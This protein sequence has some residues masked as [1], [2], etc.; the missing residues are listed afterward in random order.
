M[1]I[2]CTYVLI[3]LMIPIVPV[4]IIDHLTYKSLLFEYNI[5]ALVLFIPRAP[6]IAHID[7]ITCPYR[8]CIGE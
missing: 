6:Y 4:V 7:H 1:A 3:N 8:S 5:I 2:Y